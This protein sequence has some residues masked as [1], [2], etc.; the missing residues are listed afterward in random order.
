[1]EGRGTVNIEIIKGVKHLSR[2]I[3]DGPAT[4]VGTNE[5]GAWEHFQYGKHAVGVGVVIATVASMK[6]DWKPTGADIVEG[7][8]ARVIDGAALSVRVEF[9]STKTKCKNTLNDSWNVRSIW[10]DGS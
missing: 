4:K 5:C 9:N 7:Q 6:K 8:E 1:M 10:M 3:P 2:L